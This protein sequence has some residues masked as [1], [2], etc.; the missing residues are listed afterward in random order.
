MECQ[1]YCLQHRHL[2]RMRVILSAAKDLARRTHRSFA[3]LRMTRRTALT[4]AHGKA[5]LQISAFNIISS[6]KLSVQK[7]QSLLP[8]RWFVRLTY[9]TQRHVRGAPAAKQPA[10]QVYAPIT[11]LM[12]PFPIG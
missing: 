1:A 7:L 5:Y 10:P 3:A 4:S 11:A 2:E 9:L 8:L 12:S 6:K